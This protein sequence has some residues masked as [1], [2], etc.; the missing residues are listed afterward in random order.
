MYVRVTC[1]AVALVVD[2]HGGVF[3]AGL[4]VRVTLRTPDIH[5]GPAVL[6]RGYAAGR[7]QTLTAQSLPEKRETI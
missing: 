7:Q 6:T 5:A 1:G 4:D 3:D 2:A